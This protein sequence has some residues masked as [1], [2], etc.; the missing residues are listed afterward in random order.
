MYIVLGKKRLADLNFRMNR[1]ILG[2][3]RWL[4]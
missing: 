2:K 1:I 3:K 4:S